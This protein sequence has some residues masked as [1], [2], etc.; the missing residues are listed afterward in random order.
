MNSRIKWLYPGMRVKRWLFL[1]GA[2]TIAVG[3][4]T[5]LSIG[6]EIFSLLQ[7]GLVRPLAR[8]VGALPQQASLT[9]G[10]V[11]VFLGLVLIAVGYRQTIRSIVGV[12]LPE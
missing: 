3:V 1:I 11:I 4:G 5:S 12:I 2:G 8:A 9:L 6:L 7:V 10:L